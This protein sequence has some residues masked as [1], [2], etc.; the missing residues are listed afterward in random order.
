MTDSLLRDALNESLRSGLLFGWYDEPLDGYGKRI[1]RVIVSAIEREQAT[2]PS[3]ELPDLTRFCETLVE[4][5]PQMVNYADGA[6]AIQASQIICALSS[7][8][9]TLFEQLA[10]ANKALTTLRPFI[11]EIWAMHRDKHDP[12]YNW[13]ETASSECMW[14]AQTRAALEEITSPTALIPNPDH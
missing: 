10:A 4:R 6:L 8:A 13:C 1:I 11:A 2:P 14:C 7:K 12:G 9:H 5:A 3:A